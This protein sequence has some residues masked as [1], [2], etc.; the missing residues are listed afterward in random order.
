VQNVEKQKQKTKK[1]LACL[2]SCFLSLGDNELS[3]AVVSL[4]SHKFFSATCC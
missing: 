1:K 2:E 3:S 4:F